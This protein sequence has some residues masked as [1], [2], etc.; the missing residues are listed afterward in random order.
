MMASGIHIP[1]FL[2][3]LVYILKITSWLK[4]AA[5]DTANKSAG[6][7]KEKG[8]AL[9]PLRKTFQKSYVTFRLASHC[10]ELILCL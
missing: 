5:G 6:G 3:I 2:S 9:F 10:P 7:G 8:C 4:K 1:V